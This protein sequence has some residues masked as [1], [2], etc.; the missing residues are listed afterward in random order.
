MQ[1]MRSQVGFWV[2]SAAVLASLSRQGAE[3]NG[4]W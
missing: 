1:E 3:A 4:T 2:L